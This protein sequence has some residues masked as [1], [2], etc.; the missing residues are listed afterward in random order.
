MNLPVTLYRQIK[1]MDILGFIFIENMF[2]I[3][4]RDFLF[5]DDFMLECPE[6][7][8]LSVTYYTS[9]SGEE[10]HPYHQLS[11]NSLQAQIGQTDKVYQAIYHKNI[12]LP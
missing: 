8:F 1:D 9:V 5:L 7:E 6:P 10:F 12:P 4:I 3:T 11:P 2:E